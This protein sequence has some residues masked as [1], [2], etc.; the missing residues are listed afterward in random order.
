MDRRNDFA[1]LVLRLFLGAAFVLHGLP[2]ILHP[3]TWAAKVLPGVPPWLAAVAAFVEFGG[4]IA[5]IVGFAT[6]LFAFLIA[7]NMVVAIWFVLI[8]HGA[9]FVNDAPGAASYEKPLA[10]LAIAL[11]LILLG[12][13]NFALDAARPGKRP[14]RRG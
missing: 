13:G 1:L 5:L 11:A 14:R 3:G 6:P 8:P 4:G 2:K 9:R 10:Y 7:C 12:S